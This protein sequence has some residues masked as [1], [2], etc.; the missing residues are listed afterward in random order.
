LKST[1]KP[2]SSRTGLTFAYLIAD[3]LSACVREAG[4][5]AGHR[6]QHVAVVQRHLDR[7]VAVLVVHV[8][9]NVERVD[10]SLG[11]PFQ[12]RVQ[13]LQDFVVVQHVAGDRRERR[14]DLV[15]RNFVAAAV[16]GI[17][18][19]LGQVHARAEELHLLAHAHCRHAAGDA[20]VVAPLRPHQV[21]GLVL[22]RAGVNRDL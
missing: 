5:A 10:V 18:Q 19:R 6:A 1:I 22:D 3:R 21:V 4:D 14:P 9:D 7:F 16:Q 11:E 17:Q 20:I 8:V 13:P 2:R 12:H 15:A